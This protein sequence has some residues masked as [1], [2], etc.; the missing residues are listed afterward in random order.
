MILIC[1]DV[2]M[3]IEHLPQTN[4][5]WM[6]F[7]LHIFGPFMRRYPHEYVLSLIHAALRPLLL[8]LMICDASTILLLLVDLQSELLGKTPLLIR[9]V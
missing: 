5:L 7:L 6:I 4:I 2:V 9:A 1:Y 3:Q 8:I